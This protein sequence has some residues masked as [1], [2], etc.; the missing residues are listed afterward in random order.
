MC[1]AQQYHETLPQKSNIDI[2]VSFLSTGLGVYPRAS[3]TQR[4][5]PIAKNATPLI[6]KLEINSLDYNP[7]HSLVLWSNLTH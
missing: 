4:K 7:L 5:N 1:I 2:Q 6:S 3:K